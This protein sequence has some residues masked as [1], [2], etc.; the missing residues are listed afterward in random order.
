M[1]SGFSLTN[2]TLAALSAG[3]SK[4]PSLDLEVR[5]ERDE[6]VDP[7]CECGDD[8]EFPEDNPKWCAGCYQE[9]LDAQEQERYMEEL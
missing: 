3:L 2:F 6:T 1:Q 5:L 7:V 4:P 8:A 9:V